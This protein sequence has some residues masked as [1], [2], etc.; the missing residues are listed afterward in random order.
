MLHMKRAIDVVAFN[1]TLRMLAA[2]SEE[3]GTVAVFAWDEGFIRHHEHCAPISLVTYQP[4]A[5]LLRMHFLPGSKQ[6]CFVCDSNVVQPV[7]RVY[8]LTSNTMRRVQGNPNTGAWR[9]GIAFELGTRKAR[10]RVCGC[11]RGRTAT[12]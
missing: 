11:R 9:L 7:V 8:E 1:E 10:R 5:R 2:Y 12:S 6:L 4:D 3:S